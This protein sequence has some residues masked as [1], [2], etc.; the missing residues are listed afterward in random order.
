MTSWP[1]LSCWSLKS[2]NPATDW[3]TRASSRMSPNARVRLFS[4]T[5]RFTASS[6]QEADGGDVEQA[7]GDEQQSAE[8][9][10]PHGSALH[11]AVVGLVWS[12]GAAGGGDPPAHLELREEQDPRVER[13]LG[14]PPPDLAGADVARGQLQSGQRVPA[15]PDGGRLEAAAGL[16]R[17]QLARRPGV[18]GAEC[19]LELLC[20]LSGRLL[21]GGCAAGDAT[22]RGDGDRRQH[23]D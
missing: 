1:W 19:P 17:E 20:G 12:A 14:V 7:H 2:A 15:G 6:L 18:T 21:R 11:I 9:D 22:D 16:V 4:P 5:K 13:D 10:R 3:P 8:K 23:R